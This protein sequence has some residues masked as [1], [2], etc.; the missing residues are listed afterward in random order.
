MLT[1]QPRNKLLICVRL[2]PAQF[3]IEVNDRK[4]YAEFLTEIE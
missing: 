2:S 1:S 4:N 3:V